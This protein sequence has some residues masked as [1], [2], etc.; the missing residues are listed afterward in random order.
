MAHP[1]IEAWLADAPG[2]YMNPDGVYSYQCVDVPIDYAKWLFPDNDW[3]TETFGR[4]NANGHMQNK[5]S[6][7]WEVIWNGPGLYPQRGDVIIWGGDSINP[8]GHIAVVLESDKNGV[9]VI[10]QNRDMRA[11]TPASIGRWGYN[12]P[13][14]GM[15]MGW[16]RPKL[17]TVT[18]AS[19]KPAPIKED[20]LSAAE[21]KQIID[22]IDKKFE[23]APAR[24]WGYKREGDKR[25]AS[26]RLVDL[27]ADTAFKVVREPVKN[28]DGKPYQVAAYL[29][30][31]NANI[32]ALASQM[33]TVLATLST[34]AESETV[35]AQEIVNQI[36][37]QL[38]G[39][40]FELAPVE[41]SPTEGEAN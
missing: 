6:Q 11:N 20:T 26:Q 41:E 7:F 29:I 30:N 14:T 17:A 9:T 3:E 16:L 10:E 22:H 5:P 33:R 13:G 25:D 34:L 8:Y 21:V 2:E 18:A 36:R 39:L 32:W 24:N 27:P 15:V 35:P 40:K 31:D 12:N 1:R 38:A 28:K 23:E 37:G 19:T 4:N